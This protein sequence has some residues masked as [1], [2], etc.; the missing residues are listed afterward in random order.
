L[1]KICKSPTVADLSSFGS[2]AGDTD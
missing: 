1:G 2:V